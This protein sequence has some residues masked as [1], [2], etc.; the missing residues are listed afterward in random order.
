MY[1]VD[2][3]SGIWI[4]TGHGTALAFSNNFS[5]I[6]GAADKSGLINPAAA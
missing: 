3:S 5:P 4:A 2:A 1:Q 6:T